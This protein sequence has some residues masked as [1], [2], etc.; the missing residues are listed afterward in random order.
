MGY[1]PQIH[2]DVEKGPKN[3]LSMVTCITFKF[4]RN[5]LETVSAFVMDLR[6]ME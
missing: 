6:V 5:Q 1:T 3:C 4:N 2:S